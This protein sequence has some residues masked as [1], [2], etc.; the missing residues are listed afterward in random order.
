MF[1]ISLTHFSSLYNLCYA[2]HILSY[3]NNLSVHQLRE[4]D[5][6]SSVGKIVVNKDSQSKILSVESSKYNSHQN[7]QIFPLLV[8]SSPR[9]NIMS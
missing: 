2:T 4:N 6:D 5:T 3:H 7:I 9:F 8:P 1:G